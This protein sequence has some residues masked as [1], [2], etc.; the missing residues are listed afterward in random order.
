MHIHASAKTHRGNTSQIIIASATSKKGAADEKY[1]GAIG[2]PV[3]SLESIMVSQSVAQNHKTCPQGPQHEA[4]RVIQACQRYWTAPRM[5]AANYDPRYP[6]L[7]RPGS[8][9]LPGFELST[10]EGIA[11]HFLLENGRLACLLRSLDQLQERQAIISGRTYYPLIAQARH[12][13]EA[14]MA[15][16]I[17]VHAE[18]SGA[19]ITSQCYDEAIESQADAGEIDLAEA[20]TMKAIKKGLRPAARV[21]EKL[22]TLGSHTQMQWLAKWGIHVLKIHETPLLQEK[23]PS[24]IVT[25]TVGMF[26]TRGAAPNREV[27]CDPRS[28]ISIFTPSVQA[29]KGLE[30][31]RAECRSVLAAVIRT[32]ELGVDLTRWLEE[33]VCQRPEGQAYAQIR[34]STPVGQAIALHPRP[35]YLKAKDVWMDRELPPNPGR[36]LLHVRAW[37]Y[38]YESSESSIG[39]QAQGCWKPADEATPVH[40][41]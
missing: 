6:Q 10:R 19:W 28:G 35:T 17:L 39:N 9:R 12:M 33:V 31:S 13:G 8:T 21:L 20:L 16:A 1:R 37:L 7:S 36:E 29:F 24:P 3:D 25:E 11:L 15:C 32:L 27:L 40:P 23:D 34:N 30:M 26:I 22:S 41:D 4:A 2:R 38:H 18:K 5:R 14:S